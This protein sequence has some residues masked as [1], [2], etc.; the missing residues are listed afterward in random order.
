M[1][2]CPKCGAIGRKTSLTTLE[3]QINATPPPSQ[4]DW[5]FCRTPSCSIVYFSSPTVT[6]IPLNSLQKTPFP[7]SDSPNRLVC[8]CFNH[9]VKDILDDILI[10][11]TSTI[12]TEISKLCRNGLN[13]CLQ[14]NPEGRCCLGNIATVLR[15][16]RSG[17]SIPI[18]DN[19]RKNK[20]C[21]SNEETCNQGEVS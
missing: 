13:D 16:K 1:I 20:S 12:K 6:P 19:H 3:Y 17:I 4:D 5:F 9:T 2:S 18:E 21:C 11:S 14:L 15:S 10:N 7:K 8:F